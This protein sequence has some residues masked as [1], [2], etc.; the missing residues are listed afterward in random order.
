MIRED[1]FGGG[2]AEFV[3]GAEEEEV[4]LCHHVLE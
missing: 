4:F 2:A 3:S 1:G